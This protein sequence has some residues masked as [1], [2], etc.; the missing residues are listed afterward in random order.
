MNKIKI[1]SIVTCNKGNVRRNNQDN[2]LL[3]GAHSICKRTGDVECNLAAKS[4]FQ[5]YAVFDGMGGECY[6]DEAA[7][8]STQVAE[9]YRKRLEGKDI[10]DVNKYL[11]MYFSDANEKICQ[12][13]D[14]KKVEASGT[15]AAVVWLYKNLFYGANV[16]DSRIYLFRDNKLQQLSM[17]HT[18][19]ASLEKLQLGSSQ[20][21]SD[22]WR[23]LGLTQYLGIRTEEMLIEP[24]YFK[25]QPKNKDILLLCSDGLTES[26]DDEAI[27]QILIASKSIEMAKE[28]LLEQTIEAKGKD[29]TTMMLL[30]VKKGWFN[31][32]SKF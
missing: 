6:G 20:D 19:K 1:I 31:S 12:M 15:T 7:L 5:M 13:M 16:G 11:R 30:E 2:F 24:H 18:E 3:N 9:Y 10:T 17:D 22:S 32:T 8:I 29:N 28:R 23:E 14:E 4:K 27:C 21:R 25:L 26:I